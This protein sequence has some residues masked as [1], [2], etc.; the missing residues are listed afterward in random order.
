MRLKHY[1]CT[2]YND[3]SDDILLTI[4]HYLVKA[5]SEENTDGAV[6]YKNWVESISERGRIM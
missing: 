6:F 3:V 2:K 4:S 1:H 5:Y